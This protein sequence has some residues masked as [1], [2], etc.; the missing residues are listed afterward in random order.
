MSPAKLDRPKTLPQNYPPVSAAYPALMFRAHI[1]TARRYLFE[2]E[3]EEIIAAASLPA[4]LL[5]TQNTEIALNT[6]QLACFVQGIRAIIGDEK[7]RAYGREAFVQVAGLVPRSTPAPQLRAMSSVDRQFLRVRDAMAELSRQVNANI[8]IKWHGG[9][10]ADIFEDTGLHCY[11][12]VGE[13]QVCHTMSG[14]LEEA[15]SYLSGAKVRLS[16]TECMAMGS[17]T[18]RWHC[19]LK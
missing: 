10:E 7:A 17:L 5:T 16:E 19:F 12:Y 9:A 13:T 18:C 15:I 4:E 1:E 14:F 6:L 2:S 11:G 8:I 3:L